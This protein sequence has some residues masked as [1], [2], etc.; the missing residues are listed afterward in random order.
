MNQRDAERQINQMI[1]FIQ[2]EAREKAEEIQV[3]TDSEFMAELLSLRTAASIQI[4]EEIE[5]KRK[6][7]LTAKKI[8]RSKRVNDAKFRVM[9]E[10]NEKMGQLKKEITGRL[11][12]LSRDK[13]YGELITFLIAQ[14]LMSML[15]NSVTIR[16]RKEDL[17]IVQAQLKPAVALYQETALAAAGVRVNVDVFVDKEEFLPPGPTPG[18]VGPTCSGGVLLM[19]REGKIKCR[20]TLDDRLELAFGKSLP[21]VRGILFGVRPPP[22]NAFKPGDDAKAHH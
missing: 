16:C 7:R 13:R 22:T 21:D 19:A 9:S 17:Q 3:K 4:R 15:E 12:D 1:Q 20:N 2:Q 11:V 8:E 6:D 5:Q 10:R 14:G 18:H